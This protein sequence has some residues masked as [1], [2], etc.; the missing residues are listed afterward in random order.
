M[1]TLNVRLIAAAGLSGA[2][3]VLTGCG[4]NSGQVPLARLAENQDAYV[5]KHVITSG[6]VEEQTNA[7]GSHY[8]VLTDRAQNLVILVPAGRARPYAERRVSVSG[9]F[10]FDPKA[11]RFIRIASISAGS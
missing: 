6:R 5:G 1:L 4:G 11:G 2:T 7:D 3:A 9:R 8:Y 10:G